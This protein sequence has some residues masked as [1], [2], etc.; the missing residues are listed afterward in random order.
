MALFL[1]F[2]VDK[3]RRLAGKLA[4]LAVD[5]LNAED[6]EDN[7]IIYRSEFTLWCAI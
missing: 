6:G 5:E 7:V 4:Q 1:E 2:Q 3:I